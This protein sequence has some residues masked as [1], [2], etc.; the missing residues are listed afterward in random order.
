MDDTHPGVII[1][2]KLLDDPQK[3]R[4]LRLKAPLYRIMDEMLYRRSYLLPWLRYVGETQAKGII[5][6]VH[7]GSCAIHTD[8]GKQFAEFPVFCQKLRI[9]QSLTSVYHPQEKGQVEVTNREIVKGMERRLGKAHQGWVDELPQVLWAHITTLKSNNEETP[10]S[11]VY[12]SEA[13]VPIEIS[14]ETR[15]I[16]SFDPKMRKDVGKTWT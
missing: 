1:V 8:N 7:Q 10:F 14:I 11:L 2:G 13:V 5:Q 15:R 6:E 4:K 9:L 12:V 16:Q 3:A